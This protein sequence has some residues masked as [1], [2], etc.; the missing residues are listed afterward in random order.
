MVAA[1]AEP[2][3]GWHIRVGP[4]LGAVPAVLCT[5]SIASDPASLGTAPMILIQVLL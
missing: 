1:A 3:F 2:E 4:V 5:G